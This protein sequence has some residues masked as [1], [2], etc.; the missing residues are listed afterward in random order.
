MS[1]KDYPLIAISLENVHYVY[2]DHTLAIDG[3][4]IQ[5]GQGEKVSFIGPN[6]AGKSTLI[7][8]LNGVLKGEGEIKIFGTEINDKSASEIKSKIGIVF[9]NPDDQLFSP[10]IYED[11]AFGPINFGIPKEE[12]GQRVKNA[13]NEVGLQGYEKR[14]SLHLSYG[15]KKLASIATILSSNPDIIALDEPTSNL[16]PFHRRKIIDWIKRS[17]RTVLVA[18]HDLDMVADTVKRAIILRKGSISWDGKV[19][20]L[21]ANQ[22]LLEEN[23]LELPLSL[24]PFPLVHKLKNN[25][26]EYL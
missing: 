22:K 26:H 5:I 1:E 15:E 24:Q 25:P 8:L 10:T 13:L 18:T 23:C 4:N 20:D 7:M 21:F 17:N 6:A 12:V 11:V 3:I 2:P 16:D 14:S 19:E 9:Q